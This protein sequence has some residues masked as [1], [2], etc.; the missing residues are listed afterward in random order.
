MKTMYKGVLTVAA[1]TL[2]AS[3]AIMMAGGETKNDTA[4][5]GEK[6]AASNQNVT[7]TT[8]EK[9]GTV[10]K[11]DDGIVDGTS[12][13]VKSA[14]AAT[15]GVGTVIADKTVSTQVEEKQNTEVMD[16][17]YPPPPPGPFAVKQNEDAT[18][19]VAG[20]PVAPAQP[21][22]MEA[23]KAP[24]APTTPI[25]TVSE[26]AAV[27]KDTG[28]QTDSVTTEAK[29]TASVAE[30][31]APKAPV[32]P[33]SVAIESG[34]EAQ[35]SAVQKTVSNTPKV[36][37]NPEGK[38]GLVATEA[39]PIAPV[40]EMHK[41]SAP[42]APIAIDRTGEAEVEKAVVSTPKVTEGAEHKT[43]V[44]TEETKST[45]PVV[46]IKTP[47]APV[48]PTVLGTT[49]GAE[50]QASDVQKEVVNSNTGIATKAKELMDSSEQDQALSVSKK[51]DASE[52]SKTTELIAP[53]KPEI[54]TL[55]APEA[56]ITEGNL[57]KTTGNTKDETVVS[58]K[59]QQQ[60]VRPPQPMMFQPNAQPQAGGNNTPA[61]QQVI[62]MMP[63]Q[64]MMP[65]G[66]R[67]QMIAPQ[68]MRPQMM[69]GQRVIMV[70]VYPM[71]M[72]RPVYPYGQQAP[73]AVSPEGQ[74]PAKPSPQQQQAPA[75]NIGK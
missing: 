6:E 67:P 12:T 74:P 65:Q 69:N 24:V 45:S 8:K 59:I 70:P 49:S 27:A 1:A 29:P 57:S 54:A 14:V 62:R 42:V 4:E 5:A 52:K 58:G 17:S 61:G 68:M 60:P 41:P 9:N 47:I 28:S 50:V 51:I 36:A 46:E 38:A 15:A 13:A 56:P 66:M 34:A 72:G 55:K 11:G 19:D 26:T 48:A 30:I 71:S 37:Q 40:V 44:A 39:K 22:A 75:E 31:E 16:A 35:A 21:L 53:K 20:Q 64:I 25:S 73:I 7:A 32:A 23:P 3:A 63:P 33:T 18:T 43:N 10:V 2:V